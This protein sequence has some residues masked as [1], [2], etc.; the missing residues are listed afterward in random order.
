MIRYCAD[1]DVEVQVFMNRPLEI[2]GYAYLFLNA[3]YLHG[4]F[5]PFLG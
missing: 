4:R 2:S 5:V 3:T 1:I